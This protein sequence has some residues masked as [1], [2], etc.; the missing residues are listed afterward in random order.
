MIL[1]PIIFIII[2]IAFI[3]MY[4]YEIKMHIIF[5]MIIKRGIIVPDCWWWR[6]NDMILGKH[7]I[8]NL[9]NDM[10]SKYTSIYKT[11]ILGKPI[12]VI[13]DKNLIEFILDNSPRLFGPGIYKQNFFD[14][15]MKNNLGISIEPE[16]NIR[17]KY[18]ENVLETTKQI[19]S[20]NNYVASVLKYYYTTIPLH[21]LQEFMNLSQKVT[22]LI[23]FGEINTKIFNIF[24]GTNNIFNLFNPKIKSQKDNKWFVD[25]VNNNNCQNC[26][27]SYAKR[28]YNNDVINL[29][30]QIPH[31]IFPINGTLSVT[32]LR[33]IYLIVT[34]P[35]VYN[36]LQ[37][38]IKAV[39]INAN[40]EMIM[41]IGYLQWIILESLRVN[42]PVQTLLRNA[43]TDINYNNDIKFKKDDDLIILTG[44]F[45]RDEK[46]F[47]KPNIFNPDRWQDKNL[48]RYILMF[49]MGPQIC[50]GRNFVMMLMQI[51]LFYVFKSW[52]IKSTQIWNNK[53]LPDME[54]PCKISFEMNSFNN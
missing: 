50:P 19:H 12:I 43:L 23:I 39:D 24:D 28:Y 9:Y 47:I 49:G 41:K 11:F 2:I 15:F 21:N 33:T 16:W 14:N 13:L 25:Y 32:L 17:R 37:D 5:F 18:N 27:L 46:I 20:L 51:L 38:T 45:V 26:L 3:Y 10:K 36:K 22:S 6:L 52:N 8:T 35:N 34:N 7:M 48:F 1:I 53:D 4:W 29:Y 40:V 30:D 31:W 44:P 54:N 42:N